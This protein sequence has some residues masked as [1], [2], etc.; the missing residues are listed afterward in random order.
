LRLRGPAG[1]GLWAQGAQA[2]PAPR[3]PVARVYVLDPTGHARLTA[4][5]RA[6][7]L[8]WLE[9]DVPLALADGAGGWNPDFLA[10]APVARDPERFRADLTRLLAR[11]PAGR[12]AAGA[13]PSRLR[14]WSNLGL[15][16]LGAG[17]TLGLWALGRVRRVRA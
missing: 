15:L 12:A 4:D 3:G 7:G 16:G 14:L 10:L 8:D 17:L 6:Q 5:L 11:G 9:L 13:Q 2:L 1:G